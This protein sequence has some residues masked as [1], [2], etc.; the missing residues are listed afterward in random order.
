[1]GSFKIIIIILCVVGFIIKTIAGDAKRERK[2]QA[3]PPK[4]RS[5]QRP[6][7]SA[8]EQEILW[9]ELPLPVETSTQ[10]CCVERESIGRTA[11]MTSLEAIQATESIDDEARQTELDRWRRALIDSEILK[12]KF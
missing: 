8:P 6:N 1:M 5:P 7:Q 2:A 12:T 4:P 11:P 3:Q 10:S 9:T